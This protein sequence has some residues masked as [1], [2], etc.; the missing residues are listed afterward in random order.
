MLHTFVYISVYICYYYYFIIVTFS[1]R[2]FEIIVKI[3]ICLYYYIFT[4]S[5]CSILK[6]NKFNAEII[7]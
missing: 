5:S 1:I 3:L 7:Y 2:N 4:F 6:L